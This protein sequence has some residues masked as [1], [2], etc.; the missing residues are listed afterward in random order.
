MISGLLDR[1]GPSYVAH[2]YA[3][4]MQRKDGAPIEI[5]DIPG[6]G[7]FDLVTPGTRAW[8]EVKS[9]ILAALA[10]RQDP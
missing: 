8:K 4:A 1:L 3:R 9:R 2:D 10:L 7:H 6:A 5:I